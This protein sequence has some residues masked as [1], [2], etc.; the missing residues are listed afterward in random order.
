MVENLK[1]RDITERE[2]EVIELLS[3]GLTNN[4]IADRLFLSKNTIKWYVQQLN[5]KLFTNGR[6]GIVKE[7]LRLGLL[8]LPE[9]SEIGIIRT[10]LP[11]QT[12]PFV[13]RGSEL[14]QLQ[15]IL[16]DSNNRLLTILAPGGMGKTRIALEL[17]Q[18]QLSLHRD[19]VFFVPLESIY[20]VDGILV[21]IADCIGFQFGESHDDFKQQLLRFLSRKSM[22]LLLDNFEQV[23][24]AGTTLVNDLLK[25]SLNMKILVTSR[26][27]LNLLGETVY[28]LGGMHYSKHNS[29]DEILKYDAVRLIL[30]T[31]RRVRSD[32]EITPTN[33][34]SV[35]RLCELTQGMPLGILL[36][37]TWLDVYSIDR[38]C[39]EIQKGIDILTTQMRDL[40]PRQR[41][42][43]AVFEHT[44]QRLAK[45]EQ[46]TLMQLSVFRGGCTSEA[47][48]SITNATPAVLQGLVTKALINRT[49]TERYVMHELLRQ[50]A[51]EHLHAEMTLSDV[52]TAHA[53]YY[54]NLVESQEQALKGY[55]QV[56]ALQIIKADWDNV[57]VAWQRACQNNQLDAI[58]RSLETLRFTML[59][60]SRMD[61]YTTWLNE[62]LAILSLPDDDPFFIKLRVY[63][64][65]ALAEQSLTEQSYQVIKPIEKDIEVID[66]VKVKLL[67]FIILSRVSYILSD[68]ESSLEYA[69]TCLEMSH[70][71]GDLWYEAQAHYAHALVVG[72]WDADAPLYHVERCIGLSEQIGDRYWLSH[73][74]LVGGLMLSRLGRIDEA[75]AYTEK[76][77]DIADEL[78]DKH[79]MSAASSNL[80]VLVQSQ[81]KWELAKRFQL[82]ALHLE[83]EMGYASEAL[84]T[85]QIRLSEYHLLQGDIQ[86]AEYYLMQVA[87]LLEK[88][89]YPAIPSRYY[90]QKS[91]LV[92]YQGHYE[93]AHQFAMQAL[94]YIQT[95]M[96][97]SIV[98]HAMQRL[99]WTH[100]CL[101]TY[102][103][104]QSYLIKVTQQELR[105]NRPWNMIANVALLSFTVTHD[106]NLPRATAMM[107]LVEHHTIQAVW[108]QQHPKLQALRQRLRDELGENVYNEALETGKQ[109]KARTVLEDWLKANDPNY[110]VPT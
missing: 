75:L 6:E 83:E 35:N 94:E 61:R 98:H 86:N 70:E 36:A 29:R 92:E 91:M 22:L 32:W 63:K 43:R 30:Q 39:E 26:E 27:K 62:A 78:N 82:R 88:M 96:N 14:D 55:H 60:T 41:S 67:A 10:N 19:G 28:L 5:Q 109:L 81:G 71:L 104:A 31:A 15:Q 100:G 106:G 52:W 74:Y 38:I 84:L 110:S 58:D 107:A 69:Q 87:P 42:I 53:Q 46:I 103:E 2:I 7:A 20:D 76:G 89:E 59:L 56:K 93:Q 66:D 49:Q 48:E 23:D 102:D 101:D 95:N 77:Y 24:V 33:L 37:I 80:S 99:V 105:S 3:E 65:D 4:E 40:P 25:I 44:W 11:Y 18:Q 108:L 45:N 73:G 85:A 54:L 17:A 13:G 1:I 34:Q 16:S 50:Y 51:E 21:S 72:L 8:D 9:N 79:T 90:T 57:H 68:P 64:A 12:T 97:W 47:L